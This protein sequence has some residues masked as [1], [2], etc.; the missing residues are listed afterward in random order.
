MS[1]TF[2]TIVPV[3]NPGWEISHR[4]KLLL[5]GSCFAENIGALLQRARF[6]TIINPHG[7][8]FNP[9]SVAASIEDLLTGKIYRQSDLYEN[10]GLWM[11]LNHHGRFNHNDAS[12][13]L[14][15]INYSIA[16]GKEQL[17]KASVLVVT[18]GSAWAYRWNN[19]GKIVANCHKIPQKHFTKV[20][21]RHE[22][23]VASWN[24]LIM[25]IRKIN[26]EIKV[27]LTVSPVRHW[28]DGMNEN[29]ISKAHLLIAARELCD[30]LHDVVY[31]PSYEIMLDE[32]RDYRFYKED[33]L[34][35]GDLAIR[36]IWQRLADKYF[37]SVTLEKLEALEPRLRYLEHRPLHTSA[38]AHAEMCA[39]KEEE[40]SRI[41]S[42]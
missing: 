39:Q 20:F 30:S 17:E 18:W 28:R 2:R 24:D 31:F 33:M 10:D 8:V 13:V 15:R 38:A 11:S 40:I 14:E 22:Q 4:D 34:H 41:L 25:S 26:P 21:I 3:F 36:Y 7:I 35:P 27:M 32:L 19:D 6:D 42:M 9:H 37:S 23:I 12:V 29:Q 5:L 16:E 1:E